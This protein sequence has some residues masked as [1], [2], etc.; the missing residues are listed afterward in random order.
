M[1]RPILSAALVILGVAAVDAEAR[2]QF[3]IGVKAGP[4]IAGLYGVDQDSIGTDTRTSFSVSVYGTTWLRDELGIRLEA[5]YTQK[6]ATRRDPGGK[7]TAHLDYIDI[8]LLVL[9]QREFTRRRL[10]GHMHAGP[11][12]SI[13][14]RADLAD[15]PGGTVD[16]DDATTN[17]DFS[18]AIGIGLT[19]RAARR[20]NVTLDFRYTVGFVSI[21][22]T[23][24]DL[25]FRNNAFTALIGLQ[26][27]LG[28]W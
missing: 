13:R 17:W 16:L 26:T 27:P 24:D 21:D 12:V 22:D 9:F 19:L 3:D 6:G 15:T 25:D 7:V 23:A 28:Y 5:Q 1:I 8:P 10:Y 11:V 4:A 20:M 18:G 14:T 2:K